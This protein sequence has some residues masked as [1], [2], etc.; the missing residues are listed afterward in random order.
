[1]QA[2]NYSN[3][4][5][6]AIQPC[7]SMEFNQVQYNT[8]WNNTTKY[9]TSMEFNTIQVWNSTLHLTQPSVSRKDMIQDY[10][11]YPYGSCYFL[12]LVIKLLILSGAYLES[13]LDPEL[14]LLLL[15]IYILSLS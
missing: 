1:M 13:F 3:Q 15:Y 10:S 9:N 14:L 6:I 2:N 8:I 4:S 11:S 12:D 7:T 5:E